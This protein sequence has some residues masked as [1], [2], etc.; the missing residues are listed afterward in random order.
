[1]K[2]KPILDFEGQKKFYNKFDYD[3]LETLE[4]LYE[5]LEKKTPISFDIIYKRKSDI[6]VANGDFEGMNE[7]PSYEDLLDRFSLQ[8][9]IDKF[10]DLSDNEIKY[11]TEI[12]K[13]AL[14]TI[15]DDEEANKIIPELKRFL[16]TQDNETTDRLSFVIGDT[17]EN[18]LMEFFNKY[19]VIELEAFDDI[20]KYS[21]LEN[22]DT[23]K[24]NK[25]EVY[26]KKYIKLTRNYETGVK[27][28]GFT[29]E[30]LAKKNSLLDDKQL[31]L[32]HAIIA[33]TVM[34]VEVLYDFSTDDDE[35]ITIDSEALDNLLALI[36]LE[37]QSR[38]NNKN[39]ELIKTKP[40]PEE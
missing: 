38:I 27:P 3:T 6:A 39:K 1:M 36:E 20:L 2:N 30:S 25:N 40:T 17:T 5:V 9:I 34:N 29:L 7:Y 37:Q 14:S 8:K 24:R 16:E 26:E 28:L 11:I 15:E 13:E 12:I 19:H 10:K 35:E 22:L 21:A 4:V 33:N 18:E 23:I 32:F 31:D